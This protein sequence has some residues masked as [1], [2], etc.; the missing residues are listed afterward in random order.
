M[1]FPKHFLPAKP[2]P[3]TGYGIASSATTFRF[4]S[5]EIPLNT[6]ESRPDATDYW[7]TSGFKSMHPWAANFVMSDGS[8][9]FIQETI[10]YAVYNMLGNREDGE[11]PQGY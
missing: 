8:S 1:G 10:D 5:T 2:C 11:T 9:Q 3:P 6:M 7:L 4:H